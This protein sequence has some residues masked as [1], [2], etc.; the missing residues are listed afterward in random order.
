MRSLVYTQLERA[1]LGGVPGLVPLVRAYLSV[2]LPPQAHAHLEDGEAQ[3]VPIG[4]LIFY[5]LRAGGPR[6][7]AEA[8][9]DNS[10]PAVAEV[11]PALEQLDKNENL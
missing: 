8:A 3:G 6:A 11:V 2:I 9:Q 1:N 7:A 5:C 10:S 4:A